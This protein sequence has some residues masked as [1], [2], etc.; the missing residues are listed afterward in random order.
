[1]LPFSYCTASVF[2]VLNR[3][4]I[5]IG[6]RYRMKIKRKIHKY[7]TKEY[8]KIDTLRCIEMK[9]KLQDDTPFFMSNFECFQIFLRFLFCIFAKKNRLRF[10]CFDRVSDSVYNFMYGCFES[11]DF[12]VSHTFFISSLTS[13]TSAA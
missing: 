13:F 8:W 12:C 9:Q 1:M 6:E 2:I 4:Y 10:C 7:R 5:Q 11:M 3:N